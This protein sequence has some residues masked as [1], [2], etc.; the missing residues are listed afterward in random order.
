MDAY[1]ANKENLVEKWAP[2]LEGVDN[3]YTRKVTAQLL[4]NQAKAVIADRMDEA[5][6]DTATTTG[7]IGT[8]QK[9]ALMYP[10]SCTPR[11]LVMRRARTLV[12]LLLPWVVRSHLGL[13]L[14]VS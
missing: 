6:G 2:V 13:T 12:A 3:D 4:E 7:K 14:Q 11:Q 9:F 10:T 1:L 5:L 8:F